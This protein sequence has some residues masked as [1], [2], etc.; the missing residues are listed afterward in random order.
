MQTARMAAGLPVEPAVKPAPLTMTQHVK[1][2]ESNVDTSPSG[3][4]PVVCDVTGMDR[5]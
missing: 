1:S 5:I 3:C 2:L 4:L